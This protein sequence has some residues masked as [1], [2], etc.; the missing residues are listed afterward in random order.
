MRYVILAAVLSACST[1]PVVQWPQGGGVTP[2][3]LPQ[4]EIMGVKAPNT[5]PSVNGRAAE[6][7][8]WAGSVA[9]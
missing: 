5:V 1:Y 6:L 3:L 2:A 7:Q 9:R 4:A 8:D